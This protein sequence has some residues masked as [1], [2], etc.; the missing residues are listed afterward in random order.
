MSR[1]E[2]CRKIACPPKMQG[3][4]PFGIHCE[5]AETVILTYEEYESIRISNYENKSQTEAANL[6]GISRP[7]FTRI[8][9]KALTKLTKSL[10][11][12]KTLVI[13][14]GNYE[15]STKWYRCKK[16]NKIIE[17][18][19]NHTKCINCL[20]FSDSELVELNK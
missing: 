5:E 15:M 19:E 17:G 1:P 16:C 2:I 14:G 3:F 20:D 7:T 11:E 6:M 9:N 18:I 10:I 12:G 4:K 13:E 8:H